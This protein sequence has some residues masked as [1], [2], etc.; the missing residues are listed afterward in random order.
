[1]LRL[2]ALT[3]AS[4]DLSNAIGLYRQVAETKPDAKPALAALETQV[5]LSKKPLKGTIAQINTALSAELNRLYRQLLK[6]QP[7][8]A[9]SLKLRI[10]VNAKGGA[11]DEDLLED[12]VKSPELAANLRWNAHDAHYPPQAA[13]YTLKFSLQP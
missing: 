4:G 5:G 11:D 12:T 2:A 6:K 7:G 13:R 1:M 9:G 3:A 10:A 8:L